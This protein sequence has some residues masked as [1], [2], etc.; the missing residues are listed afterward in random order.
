MSDANLIWTPT[1]WAEYVSWQAED[2]KT[3]KRINE[4][5]KDIERNGLRKGKGKPE[6]L[7]YYPA[8]SRRIDEKNRLVYNADETGNLIVFSCKGHY[9]DK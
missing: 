6:P 8:W 1:A 5:L 2:R 4:L 3:L 9:Q 7:R